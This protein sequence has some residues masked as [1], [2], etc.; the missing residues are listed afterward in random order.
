MS[1]T[2]DQRDCFAVKVRTRWEKNAAALLSGKGYECLLPLFGCRRRW[3]DRTKEVKLPLFPGYVFCRFDPANR[4]PI[5]ITPGVLYIVGVGKIPKPVD[6]GE[7]AAL[8]RLVEC[9]LPS[10][11]WPFLQ[12]GQVAE[13]EEG[14]LRG[15][16]GI[17]VHIKSSS[18]L[19]LSVTLLSRSV[20]VEVDRAWLSSKESTT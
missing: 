15:L 18:Q 6:E 2:R 13:I 16:T 19:I 20:A 11:P 4:L 14:P 8:H 10:R 1:P 5:L 17:V 7:V 12:V 9:G 3:S